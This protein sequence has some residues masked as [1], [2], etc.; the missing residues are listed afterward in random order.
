MGCIPVPLFNIGLLHLTS[1]P[2]NLKI[3]TNIVICHKCLGAMFEAFN[4]IEPLLATLAF[5]ALASDEET[6]WG[7]AAN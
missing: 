1:L 6:N 2:V 7:R 5:A 3:K 4:A